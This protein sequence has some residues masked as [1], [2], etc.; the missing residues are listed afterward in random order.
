MKGRPTVSMGSLRWNQTHFPSQQ[1]R[2]PNI[3]PCEIM[4]DS[5]IATLCLPVSS[6]TP[7]PCGFL[8]S[9]EDCSLPFTEKCCG[10]LLEPSCKSE[11]KTQKDHVYIALWL[12]FLMGRYSW[13][14]LRRI[15]LSPFSLC[16][17]S[18]FLSLPPLLL[19]YWCSWAFCVSVLLSG[20]SPQ[21]DLLTFLSSFTCLPSCFWFPGTRFM[22]SKYSLKNNILLLVFSV[23]S[24]FSGDSNDF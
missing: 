2:G 22:F 9:S 10:I 6:Y 18:L 5:R 19:W 13:I 3:P 1:H 15:A 23:F 11:A 8:F 20:K 16:S 24:F 17:L 21:V 12:M 7:W 14:V 4:G